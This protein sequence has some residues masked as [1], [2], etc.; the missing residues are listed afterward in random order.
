MNGY[1]GAGRSAYGLK[2]EHFLVGIMSGTSLDGI[3]AVLTR[4]ESAADGSLAAIGLAGQ[5]SLPYT[6]ELKK[7]LIALCTPL[8]SRIDSSRLRI[9]SESGE[10]SSSLVL[11]EF[12]ERIQVSERSPVT[13][14]SHW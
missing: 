4:V 13:S 8:E 2:R 14:S 9:G 7:I 6:P 12:W 10:A 1:I 3:D 5:A 11:T